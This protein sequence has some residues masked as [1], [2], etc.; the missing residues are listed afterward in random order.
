MLKKISIILVVL[1][2]VN[3]AFGLTFGKNKVNYKDFNWKI[4]LT[5]NFEIYFYP[6]EEALIKEF[7]VCSEEAYHS[8]T[9]HLKVLPVD[10]VKLFIYNN[11]IDFE[12]TNI[13]SELIGEGVGGFTEMFKDRIVLPVVTSPKRMKEVITHEFTHRIQFE[14]L[15][16]GFGKSYKLAKSLFVPL[17]VMEG[18]AEYEAEDYDPTITDMLLRDAVIYD[19][20]KGIDY[21]GSFNYIDGRDAV[22][23]YKESQAIFEYIAK[24]YG[25]DKIGLLLKEFTVFSTT[26]EIALMKVLGVDTS[27]FDKNWQYDLKVKYWNAVKDKK[28][29][30]DYGSALTKDSKEKPVWNTKP[31]F[32]FTGNKIIFLSDKNNY[33]GIYE[34]DLRNNSIR[35]IVGYQ[36]DSI[37]SSGNALSVS[38]DG[39]YLAFAAKI[40]GNQK[41]YIFDL[42][43]NKI[44][45][46]FNNNLDLVYSPSFGKENI[47]IFVGVKNGIS[48]VWVSNFKGE[49]C[50]RITD[51]RYDDNEPI[52]SSDGKNIIYVSERGENRNLFIVRD[53][54][55]KETRENEPFL[56]ANNNIISP[57][58]SSK[59][60]LAFTADFNNVYDL[61]LM[62]L[63]TKKI[64]KA[65]DVRSG[66]FAPDFSPDGKKAVFSY[67]EQG[68]YNL[69]FMDIPL[70]N[71]LNLVDI[72]SKLNISD[73]RKDYK[74]SNLPVI[75]YNFDF[76]VDLIYFLV[77]Y[78]TSS[79]LVGGGY[80]RASDLLGYHSLELYGEIIKELQN[81]FQV[82]YLNSAYRTNFGLSL[83]SWTTYGFTVDDYGDIIGKFSDND[84]GLDIPII[85]PFNRFYRIQFDL[86]TQINERNFYEGIGDSSRKLVNAAAVS[87]VRDKLVYNIDEPCG[88]SANNISVV[89]AENVFGG[90]KRFTNLLFEYQKF[91]PIDREAMLAFRLFT[92]ASTDSDKESFYIGGSDTL[93]GYNGNEYYGNN[94][95]LA[96]IEFRFS[97]INNI[98]YGLWPFNWLL[99]K[100]IKAVLFVDEGIVWNGF[101]YFPWENFRNSVGVGLRLHTFVAEAY[102]LI[103]RFDVARRTDKYS[104][105]VYYIGIGHAF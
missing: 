13:T 47:L 29:A 22:L 80:T 85:Y 70:E 6:E 65:T 8:V 38:K 64:Y 23:M 37:S 15:Y 7:A 86:I 44:I 56:Q 53:F 62:N 26:Q 89:R 11:H 74:F 1:L 97:L 94:I 42:I 90:Q 14:V 25:K 96:N 45:H 39:K 49:N 27:G 77:G 46:E 43:E 55:E 50:F 100:K 81:G 103:L 69:Y 66:V 36:F 98:D 102:P 12:Q 4:I 104:N 83:F 93:R 87:F 40:C 88:G 30:L 24:K 105:E 72:N 10:P 41:I 79:G 35:E 3:Y 51:D 48:D 101:S 18:M 60:Y 91:L 78:D 92:G 28:E 58:L 19:K 32:D 33:T 75:P 2:T 68:C 71:N 20:I 9:N 61:Y 34:M 54:N 21:L 16:G 99:I 17:W 52:F 76:S 95:L 5:N 59:E 63:E 82:N 73:N 84:T 67:Y 31:V 57:V